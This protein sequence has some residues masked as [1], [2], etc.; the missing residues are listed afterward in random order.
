M[1]ND[2]VP[3]QDL[4]KV[5]LGLGFAEK[6]VPGPYLLF[7]HSPSGTVL[8]Y[9]AYR[10]GESVSWADLAMLDEHKS[11]FP[12]KTSWLWGTFA[13]HADAAVIGANFVARSETPGEQEESCIW[14]PDAG[15]PLAE[16]TFEHQAANPRAPWRVSSRDG[17]LDV[18]FEPEGIKQVRHQLGIFA[19]DYF[20]LLEAP[21]GVGLLD[22]DYHR[23][24]A[25]HT[26]LRAGRVGDGTDGGAYLVISEVRKQ[27]SSLGAVIS[28]ANAAAGP[29]TTIHE[30][31]A[32][33]IRIMRQHVVDSIREPLLRMRKE[34]PTL[35]CENGKTVSTVFR[36]SPRLSATAGPA[37]HQVFKGETIGLHR[38]YRRKNP[39]ARPTCQA[40]PSR[41]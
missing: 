12:Y 41:A 39:G 26:A 34:I 6:S 35:T 31:S 11:F 36:S 30:Q 4:R 25:I 32:S 9:R 16:I 18:T 17:R 14:T 40:A 28:E 37:S 1:R 19:I 38:R 23:M 7:E 3:F 8:P 24:G 33:L 5:L 29:K 20:Q 22:A 21:T 15:E 13:A 10:T 2:H 27:G